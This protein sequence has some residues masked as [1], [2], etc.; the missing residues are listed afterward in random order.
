MQPLCCMQFSIVFITL[1]NIAILH[2]FVTIS[3]S[4]EDVHFYFHSDESTVKEIKFKEASSV[5][6]QF[7][8]RKF[9]ILIIHG[10]WS[11]K[12]SEMPTML[13]KAYLE[14]SVEAN[15]IVVDWGKLVTTKSSD[16]KDKVHAYFDALTNF[17]LVAQRIADFVMWLKKLGHLKYEKVQLVGHSLGAHT[18]GM[19]GSI[20]WDRIGRHIKRISGLDPAG[21]GFEFSIGIPD[22]KNF[23][24]KLI[25]HDGEFVDVYHTS[26]S[27]KGDSSIDGHVDFYPNGGVKQPG[28]PDNDIHETCDHAI[29]VDYFA[30]TITGRTWE[31][32][33]CILPPPLTNGKIRQCMP[34]KPDAATV[35]PGQF[36]PRK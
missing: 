33:R 2:G 4:V 8:P 12:D 25:R 6:A 10:F 7:S 23:S 28:C 32:C 24:R 20:I 11:D 30:K 5:D 26:M 16:D 35:L 31:A 21:P 29:V 18:A 19:A 22:L 1:G 9:T 15:I 27:T 14:S 13:T 3:N 34:C 36:T 17:P